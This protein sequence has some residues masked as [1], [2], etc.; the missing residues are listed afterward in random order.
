MPASPSTSRSAGADEEHG[1][2]GVNRAVVRGVVPGDPTTRALRDGGAVLAFDVTTRDAEGRAVSAPVVWFDP[3]AAAGST[4]V[5][6]ADV[7]VVGTIRRRFFVA[8]G[9][10]QS[11]TELV[12]ATVLPAGRRAAV[13]KAVAEVVAELAERTG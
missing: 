9:A 1:P 4:V 6:G 8:G 2:P 13:R 7:V 5:A 12:A 11:R 3:P 10:T